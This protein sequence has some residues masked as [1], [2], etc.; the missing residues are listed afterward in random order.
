MQLLDKKT[1]FEKSL[2]NSIYQVVKKTGFQKKEKKEEH[3]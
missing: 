2:S 1:V 3:N